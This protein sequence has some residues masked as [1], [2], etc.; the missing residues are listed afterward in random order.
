[1]DYFYKVLVILHKELPRESHQTLRSLY[2][3]CDYGYHG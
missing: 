3:S 1:M 2:L